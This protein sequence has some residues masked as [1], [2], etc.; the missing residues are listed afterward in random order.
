MENAKATEAKIDEELRDLQATLE[1]IEKVRPFEDLTVRSDYSIFAAWHANSLR[2][3]EDVGDAHPE[4]VK[5]VETMLKKGKWTVPGMFDSFI[6]VFSNCVESLSLG[7]KEKFG[8]L[9]LM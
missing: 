2:Q 3:V 9:S 1:N 8:D 6:F 4:I 5:T 7:Y